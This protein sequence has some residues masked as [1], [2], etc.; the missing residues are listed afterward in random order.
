MKTLITC[1]ITGLLLTFGAQARLGD[2]SKQI[3][4]QY[5]P[6]IQGVPK[7]VDYN[8]KGHWGAFYRF[9]GYIISVT[10]DRGQCIREAYSR[11]DGQAIGETEMESFKDLNSAGKTWER[12]DD[13]ELA[14][15]DS[16][17]WVR[18]DNEVRAFYNKVWRVFVVSRF[19]RGQSESRMGAAQRGF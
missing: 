8:G 10:F 19:F 2:T 18:F 3:E 13:R 11:C 15:T 1:V 9:N 5:G 12:L 7:L 6:S 17:Q 16:P 4:E 14:D